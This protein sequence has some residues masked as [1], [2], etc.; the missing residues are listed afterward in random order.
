MGTLSMAIF[1]VTL[2]ASI[3]SLIKGLFGVPCEET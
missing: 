1:I 2:V 3:L